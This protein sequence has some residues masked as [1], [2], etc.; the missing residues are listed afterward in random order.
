MI[1]KKRL[2]KSLIII[3]LIIII[4]FT[5]IQIRKTLARYE[6]TTVGQRDVDVAFWIVENS[7]E[8]QRLLI[9]DIYPRATP[10]EYTFTVSNFNGTKSAET[11]LDYE[12]VIT[13]T[14]N[15]PLSYE[16]T[17]N[18]TTC[19]KTERLYE[20]DSTYIDADKGFGK[21]VYREIKLETVAN[22]LK[23]LQENDTTDTFII[24]VTF[25]QQYSA[26]LKYAD[27]MEDIKIDL[28]A[29]QVIGE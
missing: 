25:P 27:L 9:D 15:L 19:T 13:T 24:K 6:T 14:T 5:A 3:S 7:F 22:N 8:S 4:V 21:T 20:D 1:D 23:M 10:F 28:S 29:K 2:I 12:I 26:N 16:I 17:K 18:G 11:D